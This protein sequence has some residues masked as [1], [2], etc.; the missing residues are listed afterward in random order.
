MQIIL[1]NDLPVDTEWDDVHHQSNEF[2]AQQEYEE[3][4]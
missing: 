1:L 4:R 3:R 2:G